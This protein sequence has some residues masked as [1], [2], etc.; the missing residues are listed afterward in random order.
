M[1]FLKYD[2]HNIVISIRENWYHVRHTKKKHSGKCCSSKANKP[3]LKS[4]NCFLFRYNDKMQIFSR[5]I[6][7]ILAVF[8]LLNA[9]SNRV[10][11]S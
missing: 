4:Q 8:I 11:C 1:Y 3:G 6:A 10:F 7:P 2:N 9:K 5:P